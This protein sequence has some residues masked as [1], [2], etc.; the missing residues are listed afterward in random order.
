MKK[1]FLMT[2]ALMVLS[3][4]VL[5][6]DYF[7]TLTQNMKAHQDDSIVADMHIDMDGM[8]F[9]Y[10]IIK[11]GNNMRMDYK[12][13]GMDV[14]SF[15]NEDTMTLYMPA[16]NIL[17][18]SK[19]EGGNPFTIPDPSFFEGCTVGAKTSVNGFSCQEVNCTKTETAVTMCISDEFYIPVQTVFEGG[20][21]EAKKIEKRNF[22]S[23][24][25]T[26][27]KKVGDT[28]EKIDF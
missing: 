8:A 5:A 24:L 13:N 23:K 16:Q 4:P 18:T 19:L 17:N 28:L 14:S 22:D 12:M 20:K 27:P 25:L 3:T 1:L 15:M 26:P 10:R 7:K 9:P 2:T 11:K 6:N 21:V